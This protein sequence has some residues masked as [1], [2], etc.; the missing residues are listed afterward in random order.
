MNLYFYKKRPGFAT[1]RILQEALATYYKASAYSLKI[2]PLIES[3]YF[4]SI[5]KNI[6]NNL[7]NIFKNKINPFK[8]LLNFEII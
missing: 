3:N 5:L 8:L 1:T 2:L 7:S 6:K 4:L